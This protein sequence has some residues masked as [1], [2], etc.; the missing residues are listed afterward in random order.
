MKQHGRLLL[1]QGHPATAL[2]K[3]E[4]TR[5]RRS[6]PT[7]AKSDSMII[8]GP[9]HKYLPFLLMGTVTWKASGP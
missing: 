4:P 9:Q 8:E 7:H 5:S 6:G 1:G 3:K 2:R